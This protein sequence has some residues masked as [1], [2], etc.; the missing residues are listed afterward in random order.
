MPR[1]DRIEFINFDRIAW[2]CADYGITP[3]ALAAAVGVS[4]DRM[5]EVMQGK[6][7]LTFNQLRSIAD[8]FGRGVLFFLEP[9]SVESAT[10]HT[11]QFRTLA[12]QKPELSPRLKALIE[13]VERQRDIFLSLR[14]DLGDADAVRFN[15]PSVS[16]TSVVAVAKAARTW[17]CT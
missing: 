11:A 17:H 4:S 6:S 16:D 14:N 12:R 8:H 3:E 7:G 15:A 1:M 5:A 9:G 2:C 13:R 10:V